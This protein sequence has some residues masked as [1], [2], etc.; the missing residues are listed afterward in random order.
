MSSLLK[1]MVFWQLFFS[2]NPWITDNKKDENPSFKLQ[3]LEL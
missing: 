1:V 3:T 2:L